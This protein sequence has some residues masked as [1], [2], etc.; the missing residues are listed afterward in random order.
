[1]EKIRKNLKL[2]IGF[3]LVAVLV[4]S[5][6]TPKL[7]PVPPATLTY[8]VY[9]YHIQ[10][11]DNESKCDNSSL[12]AMYD[13][14]NI[15]YYLNSSK[16]ITFVI[17][18]NSDKYLILDKSKC[19]VLYDGYS[20]ELFKDVRSSRVTTFNDVQDAINNVS[21][22]TSDAGITLSIPP[23]SK[24]ELPISETNIEVIAMPETF[25]EEDKSLTP[26]TTNQTI[27][28][29]LP[30]SRDYKLAKWS[31]SRNRLYV[32]NIRVEQKTV[33][34]PNNYVEY[35]IS[36][37]EDKK[38]YSVVV[39]IDKDE[40]KRVSDMNLKTLRSQNL[41][42]W[43]ITGITVGSILGTLGLVYLLV[44]WIAN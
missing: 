20:R 26:Y 1:M 18:N 44:E 24:W 42:D 35:I 29:V 32:G 41:S 15:R 8:N 7:L 25:V 10:S 2:F 33:S 4:T 17:E 34:N 13:G 31:T 16:Q 27:E 12:T 19:Y 9:E 28:F 39:K 36:N 22:N 6:K 40:Y 30:Y 23:Y 14:F 3:L 11:M 37:V 38:S 21:V 5:C 43:E